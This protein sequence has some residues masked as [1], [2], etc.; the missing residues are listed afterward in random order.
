MRCTLAT[1]K[2]EGHNKPTLVTT[3]SVK[4]PAT[5]W[6]VGVLFVVGA[7]YFPLT[8]PSVGNFYLYG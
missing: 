5:T 3:Q 7:G 2:T 6:T 1:E 8:S 4:S